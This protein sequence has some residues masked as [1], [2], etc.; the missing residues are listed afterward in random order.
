[1]NLN[2]FKYIVAVA[3]SGSYSAAAKS[4]FI[5]QPSLSQRVKYIEG[6]YGIAIFSRDNSGVHLTPEGEHFLRYARRILN[7]EADLRAEIAYQAEKGRSV[8]R[9]GLSWIVDSVLFQD[10]V[11]RVCGSYPRIR[12]EV[13]EQSSAELQESLLAN[14]LDVAICYLP[15]TSLDLTYRVIFNDA[16]VL[17][18][19]VG[20]ALE[21]DI[22]AQ[23]MPPGSY[24]P[25]ALLDHAPFSIC[26]AGSFLQRYLSAVIET[27]QVHPDIRHT[28]KSI[29][30]LYSFAE[31]GIASTVLFR[32]YISAQNGCPYYFL[33]SSISNGL[34][35][36]L[37]WRKDS[38]FAHLSQDLIEL[39]RS[40]V[41][42]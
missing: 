15:I 25:P 8:L 14:K 40:S 38:Q 3:E 28:I 39:I 13:V 4:L 10:L 12:L 24:V 36:A 37:T 26:H 23:R 1:M 32:S 34:Q 33:D 30:M 27:E 16:Y 18:P 21:R 5:T 29:P 42:R 31:K 17:L 11:A 6:E 9:L 22:E 19:A 7:D 35:L 20:S 2:D 41:R